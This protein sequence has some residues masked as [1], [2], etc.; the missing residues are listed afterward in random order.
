M[1]LYN[2]Q[3]N[4]EKIPEQEFYKYT[5]WWI[6]RLALM[7]AVPL[8]LIG[9]VK[10]YHGKKTP[11]EEQQTLEQ[12]VEFKT[13]YKKKSMLRYSEDALQEPHGLI[14]TNEK[15]LQELYSQTNFDF[16]QENGKFVP[17]LPDYK[18]DFTKEIVI[19]VFQGQRPTTGY[20]IELTSIVETERALVIT[21]TIIE[22]SGGLAGAAITHPGH[23]VV[24]K[25]IENKPEQHWDYKLVNPFEKMY[26][27][28]PLHP[29]EFHKYTHD[30]DFYKEKSKEW[31][32]QLRKDCE[33]LKIPIPLQLSDKEWQVTMIDTELEPD[34]AEQLRKAGY[35]VYKY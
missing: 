6:S 12:K 23:Y 26:S 35:K 17:V 20:D 19:A 31:L 1:T 3:Q 18:P 14:I 34:Q 15:E 16:R 10:C 22:P 30:Q 8:A 5:K 11:Q 28:M 33:R 2:T 4:H 32:D 9:S 7:A 13:L 24:C 21:S 25:K 29:E 27:I